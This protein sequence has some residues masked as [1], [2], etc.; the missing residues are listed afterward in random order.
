[1]L[2]SKSFRDVRNVA[3]YGKPKTKITNKTKAKRRAS[4]FNKLKSF[5]NKSIHSI[6]SVT[7]EETR[8]IDDDTNSSN[9]NEFNNATSPISISVPGGFF[10]ENNGKSILMSNPQIDDTDDHVSNKQETEHAHENGSDDTCMVNFSNAK[11]ADFFAQKGDK[12]LTEIEIEGV[13]SFLRKSSMSHLSDSNKHDIIN[14]TFNSS[15]HDKNNN[16]SSNNNYFRNNTNQIFNRSRILST[17]SNFAGNNTIND[18]DNDIGNTTINELKVP[19]YLP[20]FDTPKPNMITTTNGTNSRISSIS[21]NRSSVRRVFNYSGVRSPY[22]N[23]V[24]FK[25]PSNHRSLSTSSANSQSQQIKSVTKPSQTKKV[26][27]PRLTNVASALVTLLEN[28]NNGNDK[29]THEM[30]SEEK[31]DTLIISQESKSLANPYSS[32]I[33]KP[34]QQKQLINS[35]KKE[36]LN[37]ETKQ[38]NFEKP[39]IVV[40]SPMSTTTTTT[41]TASIPSNNSNSLP[42]NAINTYKPTKSSSL[43]TNVVI[44][45]TVSSKDTKEPKEKTKVTMIPQTSS[46]TFTFSNEKS[47]KED[48]KTH[49]NNETASSLSSAATRSISTNDKDSSLLTAGTFTISNPSKT[50]EEE[51]KQDNT[52]LEEK[53]DKYHYEFSTPP[54]SNINIA[55]IDESKVEHFKSMF[56]F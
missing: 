44:A 3:P 43:S 49:N 41:T 11:L 6:R 14:S 32:I 2:N 40:K 51:T 52:N 38:I 15:F 33:H 39:S 42:A 53:T 28:T 16:N 22:R 21:S 19:Q 26:N 50:K 36:E 8:K 17:S 48:K 10:K 45:E 20:E 7:S 13:M 1:M 25:Y 12:P 55:T 27:G 9:K 31:N 56:V 47:R 37:S 34:I 30:G 54:K 23:T 24:I 18:N 5:I 29:N 35:R 4:L 46:F